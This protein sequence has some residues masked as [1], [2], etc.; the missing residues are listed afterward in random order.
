MGG[1]NPV[2]VTS[3]SDNAPVSSKGFLEIQATKECRF[4]LNRL[5][6]MIITHI[7]LQQTQ[8]FYPYYIGQSR[9]Q[10]WWYQ[11]LLENKT[12]QN[13]KRETM[14]ALKLNLEEA[15]TIFHSMNY[16]YHIFS[17]CL[18]CNYLLILSRFCQNHM[19]QVL[20]FF[21][22]SISVIKQCCTLQPLWNP[23]R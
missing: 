18:R 4:T 7:Y 6:D 1:S 21:H 14:K 11:I 13:W 3:N 12:C 10:N 20:L 2:G 22:F 5:R 8:Y 23:H 19:H 17:F 9:K 15:H 16:I